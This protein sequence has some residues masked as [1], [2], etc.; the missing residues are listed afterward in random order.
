MHS[1]RVELKE[2]NAFI[3]KI[4]RHHGKVQGHRFSIGAAKSGGGLCGVAVCGRPVSYQIDQKY[5]LEVTRLATDG[6][7]N[8]CSYLYS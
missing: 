3:E 5:V 2:A 8:A 7:S 6:T 4:H 1:V